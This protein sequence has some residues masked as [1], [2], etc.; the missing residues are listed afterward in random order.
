MKKYTAGSNDK[1]KDNDKEKS[2]NKKK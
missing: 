1:K 2:P